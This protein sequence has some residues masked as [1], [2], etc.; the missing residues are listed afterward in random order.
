MHVCLTYFLSSVFFL[1]FPLASSY[2]IDVPGVHSH[3]MSIQL[4]NY[5]HVLHLKGKRKMTRNGSVT[6]TKFEKRFRIG[7]NVDHNNITANLSEGVL[8]VT[9]PKL[10]QIEKKPKTIAIQNNGGNPQHF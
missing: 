4:E 8:V 7:H 10:K 1:L 6:E 9:A 5:G 3:D 2:S